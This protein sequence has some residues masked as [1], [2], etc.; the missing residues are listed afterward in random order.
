MSM[1]LIVWFCFVVC[2]PFFVMWI[3]LSEIPSLTYLE[4]P[5]CFWLFFK[6]STRLAGR[7]QLFLIPRYL[8]NRTNLRVTHA[9]APVNY[10]SP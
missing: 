5:Y 6:D 9:M 7:L 2:P 1:D 8:G 3:L 10:C 4:T